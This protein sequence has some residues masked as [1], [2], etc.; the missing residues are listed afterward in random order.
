MFRTKKS[1][2][3]QYPFPGHQLIQQELMSLFSITKGKIASLLLIALFS[4]TTAIAQKPIVP[5]PVW[6]FGESGAV[7]M[8]HYRGTT[9]NLNNDVHVPTAFH[10]G[11]G[12]KPYVSLLT[13]YRPGKVWGGM[14]NLGFDNRGGRFEGVVAPC[15]CPAELSTNISYVTI[16][17]SL[18]VAPFA[19]AFY[20]FAG[21]ALSFNV[22][23]SFTYKQDKQT[24]KRGDWSDVRRTVLSAQAGAGI[25]IPLSRPGANTQ[26]ALSPFASFLTDFGHNPR[27]VE[28]WSVYTVR[29]G[30]AIK[31]GLA[32]KGA[33]LATLPDNTSMLPD[34]KTVQFSVRAPKVVPGN[35]R[36]KETFPLRNSVFF[37]KGSVEIP[38][39]Y[40]MLTNS[41][42]AA[43][44]EAQLQE[45]QPANLTNGRS[46]RQL[47]VYYNILNI[48]GDRLRADGQS[49]ITLQGSS[50]KNPEEGKSIAE[51]VKSY[52]VSLYGINP[53]RIATEGRDKPVIPSEQPGATREMDLLKAGDRRVDI[54]STSPAIFLQVGGTTSAFLK[55]V[56]IAALQED[57]M[58]SHVILTNTGASRALKSW[59]VDV[60]DAQGAVQKYGPFTGDL[61][62]I[63]GSSILAGK[64]EG[65][66]LIQMRGVDK[67][68]S[69]VVA[70]SSVSLRKQDDIAQEGLRYSILFDF[71]QSKSIASYEKFLTDIVAPLITE[72]ALVSIH[73]HTDIIGDESYN[74]NLSQDRA[75]GTQSILAAALSRAGKKG[76]QFQTYGFG[77][78]PSM[79][80]FGNA[81]PEERFYNRTVIIDILQS[82]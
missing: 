54:V 4:G 34:Q 66:Y 13:E 42:A 20:V 44:R 65:N 32:P 39:R 81:Y 7:N 68:G 58:D 28:S 40:V 51:K 52:L 78:D 45:G 2:F 22:S 19:S 55:P 48:V 3:Q 56:Q 76:V 1:A 57:P 70:N 72:N 63:P 6:W 38:N 75:T 60:T 5:K 37:D 31:F 11:D 24:D 73:G 18:R 35:R 71:D 14:L 8:N 74:Q 82:K 16:E 17:P 27:S 77:E 67:S 30:M 15:N 61:A 9:Q 36:V 26:L 49:T 21:P 41:Q 50:D 64:T 10:K 43:F 46:A 25:D 69:T 62:S 59:T 79:A 12:I 29:A 47:A 33:R 53:S 80:P 23:R